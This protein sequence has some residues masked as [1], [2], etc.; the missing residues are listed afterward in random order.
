MLWTKTMGLRLSWK[1]GHLLVS[2][3]CCDEMSAAPH[4]RSQGHL[5]QFWSLFSNVYHV[6]VGIVNQRE[7][8][9][10]QAVLHDAFSKYTNEKSNTGSIIHSWIYL[11][12]QL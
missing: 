11:L 5:L 9:N 4:H 1:P 12:A 2:L 8:F 6:Y 7:G 3:W 10:Y